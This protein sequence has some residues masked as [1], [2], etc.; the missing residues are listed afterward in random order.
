M[1]QEIGK[2]KY[3][4]AGHSLTD[5]CSDQL[6]YINFNEG[7]CYLCSREHFIQEF[8]TWSSGN[9]NIDKIMQESQ[10]NNIY[11]K[12][13]WIPY[14][15]FQN[16]KHIADGG[17]GSVYSAKL[18]NG[19]KRKWN[20]IKQ[21]WRY[22]LI[23][24]KVALKEIKDSRYD[25]A[26][27]FKAMN[28]IND[29]FEFIAIY[30]G[31]SK[32]PSTQNYII[33]MESFDEN[34]H[35]F[36][37]KTFWGL[38]WKPK[39]DILFSTASSLVTLHNENLVH[40]DLHSENILNYTRPF[41]M[42]NID[43]DSC[44]LENNLILNANKIYGSIPYIPPEVL[45]GNKFT[46]EGD[47]YSFGGIMYETATAQRPFSD[48]A[49]DTYLMIDICNGVRPK[50]PDFMLNWIPE[51]YLN[52]MYRCWSDD[53]SERPTAAELV[54]L[55]IDVL[56]NTVN[57]NVTQQHK[58]AD[59]NQ[60]NTSKSQKQEL[61]E[62]F[63]R[64]NILFSTASSLVTLHNENLVHCDLHS[65]NILNYTRPF[66][67]TNIDLDSCK[68][69]NNLILNANKIYGS[70]PYIPPEV[71]RGN[72]FTWE[73]DIY[74]FGG[75]MYETATAQ[76]PFSDQA[77]DTYL[78][79]D[80]CNGVRPK[81]PDFMLNWIPEWYLNLMYRCWSDDPS[82][83]PTAAELVDLF[84]DVL[85]NT[86]NN[87]VTQQHKIADENQK[88]TSKSQKQELFELFSR[89]SKLHPKSCYNGR[90]IHTLHGLHD[91]LEEIK[92]GKS[93]DPNLLKSNESSI[94]ESNSYDTVL[95]S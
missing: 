50:V 43:L 32:N 37:T 15:N 56:N 52:L 39:L 8:K 73:G 86:V 25:I 30:Y 20:F 90:Y 59:E 28:S 76:R 42:T 68:L 7:F 29:Y 51:W 60:K 93:S 19:I 75:I 54:D 4:P 23:G 57:N 14:D 26:E 16:I 27:F 91:L 82:E 6:N 44:K 94:L 70:I 36:L 61:F 40:C 58:I 79:I 72:K 35:N 33:V 13:Q 78:M 12:L 62:L 81:V 38:G 69:E 89:S 9:I 63:S 17:R 31:I 55:F 66:L 22:D 85:N 46:W 24:D 21:D 71:L 11:R 34:L 49:H 64:S 65:E 53:P 47:I 74:S 80:I 5:L 83:R 41:L 87:N 18:E 45:R 92:S 84:I 48:Q 3:C 10:T 67:M 2:I 95:N 1:S 77:H 88:N